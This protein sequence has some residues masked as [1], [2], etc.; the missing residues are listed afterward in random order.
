MSFVVSLVSIACGGSSGECTP[1][2]QR[3][4][5]CSDGTQSVQQCAAD[6]TWGACQCSGQ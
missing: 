5:T 4:C 6:G 3:Q 1:D 2:A